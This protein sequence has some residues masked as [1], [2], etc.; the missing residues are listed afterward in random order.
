MDF[1]CQS[2]SSISE[3]E[4]LSQYNI[5]NYP[6]YAVAADNVIFSITSQE[7]NN[8]RKD[9]VRELAVLLIHRKAHPE[10]SLLSLPGGFLKPGET[11]EEC[12]RREVTEETGIE[13]GYLVPSGV[14]SRPDRD[15]RGQIISN[16]F[17]SV[18]P[19]TDAPICSPKSDAYDAG[20][21]S[22]SFQ[23]QNDR[24]L[25]TLKRGEET[26]AA[27][28]SG[29]GPS[30]GY[31]VFHTIKKDGLAFDHA[32][33][34][35]SALVNLRNTALNYQLLFHFLPEKFTLSELQQIY[36]IVTGESVQAANFRRKISDYVQETDDFITGTGHRPARLFRKK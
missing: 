13:P 22:V 31:P 15:P 20:W 10:R 6:T 35:C 28:L 3:E 36:E 34:V 24:Y 19:R 16:M 27:E 17:L 30:D 26:A 2:Y 29:S 5:N 33:M 7:E 12:S 14:F 21:Y 9:P 11:L 25:L 18:C 1:T 4:Y 32:E 8:Y 23:R